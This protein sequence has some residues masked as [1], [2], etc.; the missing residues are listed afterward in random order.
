V[1]SRRSPRCTSSAPFARSTP[2][3]SQPQAQQL[4][5]RITAAPRR[6][7]TCPPSAVLRLPERLAVTLQSFL[8]QRLDARDKWATTFVGV[9]EDKLSRD[10]VLVEYAEDHTDVERVRLEIIIGFKFL[11]K[12][13][14]RYV[15]H[16]SGVFPGAACWWS[17]DMVLSGAA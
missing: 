14:I 12:P 15:R 11:R 1:T 17:C 9:A 8:A 6:N 4:R 13:T 5:Q 10:T 3:D 2:L 16:Q 7:E